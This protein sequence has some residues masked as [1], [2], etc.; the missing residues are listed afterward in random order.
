MGHFVYINDLVVQGFI[1]YYQ[2]IHYIPTRSDGII[3]RSLFIYANLYWYTIYLFISL[4]I[5][6][7]SIHLLVHLP[8]YLS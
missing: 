2:L 7:P 1:Y 4:S 8:I 3:M 6:L 5:Y